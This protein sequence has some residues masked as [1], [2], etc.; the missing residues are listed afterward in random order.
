MVSLTPGRSSSV[1]L[2]GARP[3]ALARKSSA[4]AL[5]ERDEARKTWSAGSLYECEGSSSMSSPSTSKRMGSTL[6][7]CGNE[8][9]S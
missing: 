6:L 1:G 9:Y 8:D 2:R 5:L 4:A 7:S 3:S